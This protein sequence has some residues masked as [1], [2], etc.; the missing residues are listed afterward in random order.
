MTITKETLEQDRKVAEKAIGAEWKYDQML[1]HHPNILKFR[2]YFNP[3]AML[4]R[5]AWGK[6]VIDRID[7]LN[8]YIRGERPDLFHDSIVEGSCVATN[9]ILSSKNKAQAKRIEELEGCL[10]FYAHGGMLQTFESR[11]L[12]RKSALKLLKDGG[13]RDEN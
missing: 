1:G 8:A 9:I 12:F 7:E 6:E 11:A 10:N 5:I 4:E 13:E 2:E 3:A